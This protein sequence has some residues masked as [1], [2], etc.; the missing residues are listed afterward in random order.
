MTAI[1]GDVFCKNGAFLHGEADERELRATD[2]VSLRR[3]LLA[4]RDNLPAR[5]RK[6]LDRMICERVAAL[7]C[8]REATAVLT[9]VPVGSEI[10]VWELTREAWKRGVPVGLPVCNRETKTL[11]FRR[12]SPDVPTVTGAFGI[13]VP[14]ENAEIVVPD[15]RTV[16]ILPALAYDGNRGRLGYGGGYYDRFLLGFG[17]VAV[18]VVYGANVLETV[19]AEPHDRPATILVTEAG[20]WE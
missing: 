4:R 20:I 1:N 2:K 8:F 13:P 7:P 17:G 11:T 6:A 9:Y 16:C 19:F 5:E 14:P 10:D 3:Q 12:A 15:E 18:G